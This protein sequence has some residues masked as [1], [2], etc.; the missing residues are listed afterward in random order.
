[1][2]IDSCEVFRNRYL[3]PVYQAND[4]RNSSKITATL[5]VNSDI[6]G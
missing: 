5:R 1:M 2:N 3:F 4:A 6:I